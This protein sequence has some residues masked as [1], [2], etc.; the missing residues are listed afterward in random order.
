MLVSTTHS[1]VVS[2]GYIWNDTFPEQTQEDVTKKH[3]ASVHALVVLKQN[4]FEWSQW[5][6]I[7]CGWETCEGQTFWWLPLSNF[8]K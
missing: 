6:R 7:P 8:Q 4:P 1:T 2:L 5:Y 3:M